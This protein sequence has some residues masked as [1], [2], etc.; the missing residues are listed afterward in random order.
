MAVPA[1]RPWEGLSDEGGGFASEGPHPIQH[2]F[3]AKVHEVVDPQAVGAVNDGSFSISRTRIRPSTHPDECHV[4]VQADDFP[5]SE[6]EEVLCAVAKV[7][8]G[9]VNLIET[10]AEVVVVAQ[11]E[12]HRSWGAGRG[13]HAQMSGQLGGLR[14]IARY[15]QGRIVDSGNLIEK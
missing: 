6:M 3:R 15:D 4:V 11:H 8:N 14:N 5:S 2:G 9:M 10:G 1:Q 13:Q 7:S 12:M